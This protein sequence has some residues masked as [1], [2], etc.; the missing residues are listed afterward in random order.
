MSSNKTRNPE[1]APTT[2]ALV[3]TGNT[4]TTSAAADLQNVQKGSSA[5]GDM[6][7]EATTSRM[8]S[9]D[10]SSRNRTK[11]PQQQQQVDEDASQLLHSQVQLQQKQMQ[12]QSAIT[13]DG[14]NRIIVAAAT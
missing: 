8:S 9:M 1:A 6:S 5:D 12:Q 7:I 10:M 4:A 3:A 13:A 11:R 2:D 14:E